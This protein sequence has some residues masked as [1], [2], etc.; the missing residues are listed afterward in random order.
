MYLNILY[1]EKIINN[2]S[3]GS[4]GGG[5]IF[6]TLMVLSCIYQKNKNKFILVSRNLA[7]NQ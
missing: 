3:E 1:N 6:S 4:V 5:D 2:V 7:I